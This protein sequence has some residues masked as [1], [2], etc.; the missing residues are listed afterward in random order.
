MVKISV[1]GIDK[2]IANLER[3]SK[4][5][6]TEMLVAV[7]E[8]VY[9]NAKKNISKHSKTGRMENNLT[10]R[11]QKSKGTAQVFIA[12]SGMMVQWRGRPINYALF[13]HFGSRPHTIE[14]KKKKS[15]RWTS[16]GEFVF[17]KKVPHPG[18]RGDPFMVE[19]AKKTMKNLDRIF[20][21]VNNG[22]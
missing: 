16:V 4:D 22:I 19:A 5:L 2:T 3:Y 6:S 7:T 17:A 8:D 13:V 11:V 15:L 10:Q 14:P 1:K 12:D 9:D 20:Q 18:Y 21:G